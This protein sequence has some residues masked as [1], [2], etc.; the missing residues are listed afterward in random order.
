[1]H[2]RT[3]LEEA[4]RKR[5]LPELR[6]LL[7]DGTIAVVD[8]CANQTRCGDLCRHQIEH[9]ETWLAEYFVGTY[10][11]TVFG[12]VMPRSVAATVSLARCQVP[13]IA[14]AML[15]VTPNYDDYLRRIGAKSRNMLRKVERKGYRF[16]SIEW[17]DHLVEIYAINVSKSMRGGIPMTEEYRSFPPRLKPEPIHGCN[18]HNFECYG[19]V[20]GNRLVAYCAIHY[21]GE[22]AI[23]RNVLGHAAHLP[24]GIMNGLMAHVA[25]ACALRGI[26]KYL[27]YLTLHSRTREL[28]GFKK[29]VGFEPKA[30]L[31]RWPPW[32]V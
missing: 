7:G 22:L 3:A 23:I 25:R 20:C 27:N 24:D 16:C 15:T 14:L 10:P 6:A 1:V 9:W 12:D 5:F 19:C 2:A 8:L 18:A 11:A 26:V 21:C 28:D 32:R 30:V 4:R 13:A 31:V 29:R 17:S